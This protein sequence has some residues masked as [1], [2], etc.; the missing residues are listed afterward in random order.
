MRTDGPEWIGSKRGIRTNQ[1]LTKPLGFPIIWPR[2]SNQKKI[3]PIA[4][5][6][7][8][9]KREKKKLTH[10]ARRRCD[11]VRGVPL[12]W[13][14]CPNRVGG[15]GASVSGAGAHSDSEDG[16]VVVAAAV[17]FALVVMTPPGSSP[18]DLLLVID[19]RAVFSD[20]MPLPESCS[21]SLRFSLRACD[22][23]YGV[24]DASSPET[25]MER[26]SG[27]RDKTRRVRR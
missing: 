19:G 13:P 9:M 18:A 7:K 24:R 11:R 1:W 6:S 23:E 12:P 2:L 26:R 14:I 3:P 10:R 27:S 4:S 21:L 22:F 16:P 8:M 17:D 15:E 25:M 20:S 5:F